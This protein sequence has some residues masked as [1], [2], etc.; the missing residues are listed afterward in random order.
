[1]PRRKSQKPKTVRFSRISGKGDYRV[2]MTAS[3]MQNDLV[4]IAKERDALKKRLEKSDRAKSMIEGI[5]S[6]AGSRLGGLTPFGA[7]IGSSLGSKAG[8]YFARLLGHGDYNFKMNSLINSPSTAIPTFGKDG[9]RGVRITEREYIGDVLASGALVSNATVFNNS[10]Y[11]MT[12]SDPR[13]FPWLSSIAS[14]FDQWEPNGLVFEFIST[15][16]EFNGNSQALGTVILAVDYDNFDTLYSSKIQM[17]DAEGAIS[18]K[19]ADSCAAG[20]ECDPSE[21]PVKLL[22]TRSVGNDTETNLCSLG[23][24][25]I[26]TQGASVSGVV[27]GELWVTYDITFYKKQYASAQSGLLG[28]WAKLSSTAPCT[29]TGPWIVS[30]TIT[31][32]FPITVAQN[33]GVN[34]VYSF[35]QS[36]TQ[37]TY[38]VTF[39]WAA[40]FSTGAGTAYNPGFAAVSGCTL[41]A[42]PVVNMAASGAAAT[43]WSVA[44]Q[45]TI[46]AAPASFSTL[47]VPT[48]GTLTESGNSRILITQTNPNALLL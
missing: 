21:R 17:E 39:Y 44:C 16:S 35:P 14:N 41:V 23:N 11:A 1:M 4:K 13:T 37:G 34:T 43:E 25:Q 2:G 20:V 24:F 36:V 7:D 29:S 38:L 22:Y 6:A 45:I 48:F 27:L 28:L 46:N 42:G 30:P 19:S 32:N 31:G 9:K 18:I 15:S 10:S 5:A 47:L 8:S 3:E 12:P 33:V 40:S 26:A